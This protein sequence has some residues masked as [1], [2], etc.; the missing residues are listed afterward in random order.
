MAEKRRDTSKKKNSILDAAVRAFLDLGYE[1][2]S[3][4]HIAELANASKRTVYN[5]FPSKEELFQAVIG[6]FHDEVMELK[7]IK[8]S[9]DR[10]VEAQLEEFAQAKMAIAKNEIWLGITKMLL[11]VLVSHPDIARDTVEKLAGMENTLAT[12]LRAAAKD[13][14]LNVKDPDLTAEVFYAMFAGAF[15]W[16]ATIEG[17]MQDKEAEKLKQELI[18]TFL[19]R[20]QS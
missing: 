10:A 13:G 18:H 11:G 19:A 17:P 4:D 20:Y 7:Q 8:Y 5:H 1:N 9:P 15:F 16:P 2:A 6:R 3:M 14:K 12:W